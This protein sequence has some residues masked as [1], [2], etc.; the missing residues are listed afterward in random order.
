M[1]ADEFLGLVQAYQLAMGR[2]PNVVLIHPVDQ[3]EI[4]DDVQRGAPDPQQAISVE[5][6]DSVPIGQPRFPPV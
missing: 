3:D 4:E 2:F 6:D 1:T 5:R